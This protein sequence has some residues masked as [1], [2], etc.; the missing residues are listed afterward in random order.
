MS[1]WTLPLAGI[2]SCLAINTTQIVYFEYFLILSSLIAA[3]AEFIRP[4]YSGFQGESHLATCISQTSA[5]V[6]MI[7]RLRCLFLSF[8]P[9][10]YPRYRC[11]CDLS[12]MLSLLILSV[13]SSALL[14]RFFVSQ[15]S[16]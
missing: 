14:F 6:L 15:C 1:S 10:P 2:T 7:T 9:L 5:G 3:G 11:F 16:Q 12:L 13:E 8:L 4:L